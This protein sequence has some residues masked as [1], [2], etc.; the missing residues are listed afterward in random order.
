MENQAMT[1]DVVTGGKNGHHLMHC[2]FDQIPESDGYNFFDPE[3]VQIQTDPSPVYNGDNFSFNYGGF[4]WVVQKFKI[5]KKHRDAHG[6]WT[7]KPNDNDDPE[8]G[9]FQAQA[10]GGE[11]ERKASA[12]A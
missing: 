6:H 9:T 3:T 2:Y 10:G 5:S 4:Q 7:A 12:S 8:S 11:G 1:I